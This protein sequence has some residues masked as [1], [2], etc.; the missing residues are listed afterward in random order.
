MAFRTH[1]LTDKSQIKVPI[2]EHNNI[3]LC[4]MT[5]SS[6]SL[7]FSIITAHKSALLHFIYT[8]HFADDLRVLLWRKTYRQS[9]GCEQKFIFLPKKTWC[10][11]VK[12][13]LY[14]WRLPPSI[15]TYLFFFFL[16]IANCA[17]HREWS[18]EHV[19]FLQRLITGG[20]TLHQQPII[21]WGESV[22][23]SCS[24]PPI[25]PRHIGWGARKHITAQIHSDNKSGDCSNKHLIYQEK[26]EGW[27]KQP[28][29]RAAAHWEERGGKHERCV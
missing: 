25:S 28:D 14:I 23:G 27:R 6:L 11:T 3:T 24:P 2:S 21:T 16:L 20:S 9:P 4:L 17:L 26:K 1:G 13:H 29:Q 15:S 10:I 19:L 5:V 18:G 12:V 22:A 8:F 7:L